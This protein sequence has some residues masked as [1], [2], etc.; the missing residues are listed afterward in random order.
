MAIFFIK[1]LWKK[2]EDNSIH[3][4]FTRFSKGIFDNKAVMNV[5]LGEKIKISGTYEVIN[6][7]VEF[8]AS[9]APKLKVDGIVI[10][11]TAINGLSGVEKK[12]L[13]NYELN[14]EIDSK[15]LA[16]IVKTSF[17]ALLDCSANG[18]EFKTKKKVPRPSSKGIDKVNDKFCI[19]NLDAK[20]WPQVKD[21]F[22][23]NLP[24]G[25]KFRLIH[26][27][28]I[29][30]IIMPK[31]EKDFEKIRIMAKRKGRLFRT[32]EVDGKILTQD[33]DFEA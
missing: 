24:D 23:F 9:L 25:K 17:Y 6:D 21:E 18:I 27:Y 30:E 13:F 16:E 15:K 32:A 11:R 5:R 19:M 1:K 28:E 3:K 4:N 33:I 31:G 8:S 14:E 26:K 20:F 7:L 22:L 12:G 29:K 2:E 10:S